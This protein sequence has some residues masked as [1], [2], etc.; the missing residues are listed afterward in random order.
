MVTT[1][2][3]GT[4]GSRLALA[5]TGLVADLLRKTHPGAEIEL[6]EIVTA[7]DRDQT[8][9]LS[10]GEGIGWFTSALQV[11]LQQ[12]EVDIAVHSYKD[13]PTKRPEGLVIAA[14]PLREDPRDALVSRDGRSDFRALP[15]GARVGTSSARRTAQLA[16][17]RPDIE[18][19][20]IRGNVDTRLVKVDAGDY[21]AAVLALA[22]L[23]RLGLDGRATHVFGFEELVPAPAQGV[24]AIECRAGDGPVRDL[25]GAIDDPILRQ[26][27]TAERSFL[28]TLGAGCSFPA[29]AY[30]EHFGSTLKLHGL[31]ARDGKIV[32]SK[33][34]GAAETAA[35][36]GS[37][38]ARELMAL[39]GM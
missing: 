6:V 11:A 18:I 36:L 23:K 34:A 3:I 39:A 12:G 13:L 22:G 24:L 19:V 30:A 15:P 17:I 32:R 26:T 37:T 7:G 9:A 10:S 14:V 29:G 20:A 21:D 16:A 28:A 2:R 4:R 1:I 31:I 27:V 5:Q 33:M 38:L 35:G 25:L 8:S